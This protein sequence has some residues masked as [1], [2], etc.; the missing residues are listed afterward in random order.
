M[1][2]DFRGFRFTDKS[3]PRQHGV[4][5]SA[6]EVT[7]LCLRSLLVL[8]TKSNNPL[9]CLDYCLGES[10]A[11]ATPAP[12][13]VKQQLRLYLIDTY[14][15]TSPEASMSEE[16]PLGAAAPMG[17][18]KGRRFGSSVASSWEWTYTADSAG[19]AAAGSLTA[20]DAGVTSVCS[21]AAEAGP[22]RVAAVVGEA[23]DS[24]GDMHCLHRQPQL[25]I[26]W[27]LQSSPPPAEA[28]SRLCGPQQQ[29]QQQ[30]Q[31]LHLLHAPSS[32]TQPQHSNPTP[33]PQPPQQQ[34]RW[35]GHASRWNGGAAAS[36]AAHMPGAQRILTDAALPSQQHLPLSLFPPPWGALS[37]LRGC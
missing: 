12:A 1:D 23:A 34:Q 15:A 33:H 36:G 9:N 19:A 31:P 21:A 2:N 29:P 24:Q 13:E 14:V 10:R 22:K 4:S 16:A 28:P 32:A 7:R 18:M 3:Q 30:Q 26:P 27:L 11:A 5:S 25:S 17:A 8:D 20:G 35:H 6:S 37:P